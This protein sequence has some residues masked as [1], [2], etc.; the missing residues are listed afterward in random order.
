MYNFNWS[1]TRS[2]SLTA[3]KAS[4]SKLIYLIRISNQLD[5]ECWIDLTSCILF[6]GFVVGLKTYAWALYLRVQNKKVQALTTVFK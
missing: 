4:L 5:L 2:V 6:V 3:D 1:V